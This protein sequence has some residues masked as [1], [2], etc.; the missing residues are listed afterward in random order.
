MF[1]FKY[2]LNKAA[3][4]SSVLKEL[5]PEESSSLKRCILD[6]F[7]AVSIL[8]LDNDLKCMLAGGSCLGAVR[9]HGF[10]PWDDDLDLLMPRSDYERLIGLLKMGA[11]GNSYSYTCPG[12]RM[13][14]PSAF[15][16]IYKNDTVMMGLGGENSPYPQKVCIDI[17]PLEGYSSLSFV[18]KIKGLVANSLRLCSN[19]V[20]ESHAFSAQEKEF[21][22]SDFKLYIMARMR[23]LF[24]RFLS[25]INHRIWVNWYD[26]LVRNPDLSGLV[27]VPTG[28]KLYNGEVFP[29]SVFTSS[30]E[31]EFEGLTVNLPSG[32]DEYLT[33]LY[34][35][36]YMLPPPENVKERHLYTTFYISDSSN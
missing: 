7:E 3:R 19:L 17:F 31:A 13:D 6:I 10:I 33:N 26:A 2:Y 16:K 23:Q 32:W 24:G 35:S 29:A 28:R 11:L 36:D 5:S 9:H 15:L 8:C 27:G 18:R 1:S 22:S 20:A 21:Y 25:I 34:G 4:N 14:S 12:G 30:I